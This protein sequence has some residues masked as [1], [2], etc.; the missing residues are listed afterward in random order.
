MVSGS[1]LEVSKQTKHLTSLLHDPLTLILESSRGKFL[2]VFVCKY[3][4]KN[5][6]RKQERER[7]NSSR[8]SG[9]TSQVQARL[10]GWGLLEFSWLAHQWYY[11]RVGSCLIAE[12]IQKWN[13]EDKRKM[14]LTIFSQEGDLTSSGEQLPWV[15]L[16]KMVMWSVKMIGRI[17]IEEGGVWGHIS[18]FSS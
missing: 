16:G 11:W 15:P 2:V 7:E 3:V 13:M 14:Y 12:S 1:C 17:V 18:W 9:N 6:Q 5:E 8:K 4:Q 10:R